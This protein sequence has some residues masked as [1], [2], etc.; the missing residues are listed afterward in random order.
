[1]AKFDPTN[2]ISSEFGIFGIPLSAEESDLILVPVPWEVTTSYGA[3]AGLGPK[4]IRQASEQ[5]DLFDLETGKAYE[6][7]FHMTEFPEDLYQKNL[8]FKNMAQ[9][10]IRIQTNLEDNQ[11]ELTSLTNAVNQACQEMSEYVYQTTKKWMDKGKLVG[12]VGGDHS[13]PLGFIKAVSEKYKSDF[14]ILHIDAHADLRQEYQGFKQS[15]AS[16]MRN[17]MTSDFKPKKLVQ[18]GIR[19]FCEAEFDFIQ[20]RSDIETFFDIHNKR[21]LMAGDSWGKVCD[22]I[23]R[24]LPENV[25]VSFDIDGLDPALCP[26]TGTPVAGGL[27]L[28]QAFY[29]FYKINESGRKIIAFD[30]N[31]VSAGA[32]ELSDEELANADWDGNV[33]ARVLYKLC[34]WT[35]K[36]AASS[37]T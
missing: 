26:N 37:K 31:E 27:S 35:A 30:V 3:G 1:M 4:I 16:I 19:D 12:L 14:G 34:G 23:I 2:T 33:G 5:L 13:T 18:V 32:T 11:N 20:S 8:K 21:R 6:Q 28:D 15:H 17:V 9:E 7:G 10:I 22:D 24:H 25:Y 36:A 29:L